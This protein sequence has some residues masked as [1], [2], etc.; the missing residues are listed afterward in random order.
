[1]FVNDFYP[2]DITGASSTLR[3]VLGGVSSSHV[4][5]ENFTQYKKKIRIEHGFIAPW[6]DH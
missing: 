5:M 1:L 6:R 2:G 3:G 4:S